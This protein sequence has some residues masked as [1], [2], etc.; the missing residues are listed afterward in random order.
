MG[1]NDKCPIHGNSHPD[2]FCPDKNKNKQ[3]TPVEKV[4]EEFEFKEER[5]PFLA[6]VAALQTGFEDETVDPLYGR[7]LKVIPKN[8]IRAAIKRID[9][10]EAG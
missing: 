7:A 9:E 2:I 8:I 6:L 10:L 4:M 5:L 3:A 1:L